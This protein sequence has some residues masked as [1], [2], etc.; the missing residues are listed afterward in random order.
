MRCHT[1]D[2]ESRGSPNVPRENDYSRASRDYLET[3]IQRSE[4]F[5]LGLQ[6]LLIK[7][8]EEFARRGRDGRQGSVDAA[9]AAP[10]SCAAPRLCGGEAAP[11]L[12]GGERVI[13]G[14]R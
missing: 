2:L 6:P 14:V 9:C 10:P 12:C 11:R 4:T 8:E 3:E 7:D 13:A 5:N 1:P